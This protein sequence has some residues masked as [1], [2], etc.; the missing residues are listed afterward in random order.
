MAIR[1]V[2]AVAIFGSGRPRRIRSIGACKGRTAQRLFV[3]LLV[4]S[5]SVGLVVT[6]CPTM[7]CEHLDSAD[8]TAASSGKAASMD[9]P[10]CAGGIGGLRYR[11]AP[12]MLSAATVCFGTKSGAATRAEGVEGR[13]EGQLTVSARF[14]TT[15]PHP[16]FPLSAPAS[17]SWLTDVAFALLLL[18]E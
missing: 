11:W 14:P 6:Q 3:C 16:N 9:G 8:R 15:Q 10:S 5:Q 17:V 12:R 7:E 13:L 2:V 4:A 18:Q 1:A